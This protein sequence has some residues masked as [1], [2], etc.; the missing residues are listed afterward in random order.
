MKYLVW[1][2][3]MTPKAVTSTNAMSTSCTRLALP[4]MV[5]AEMSTDIALMVAS[6]ILGGEREMTEKAPLIHSFTYSLIWQAGTVQEAEDTIAEQEDKIPPPWGPLMPLLGS[7]WAPLMG[8]SIPEKLIHTYSSL[9]RTLWFPVEE[10]LVRK[11][12]W[13]TEADCSLGDPF[14]GLK[15]GVLLPLLI[16]CLHLAKMLNRGRSFPV[17][18]PAIQACAPLPGSGAWV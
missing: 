10:F 13:V 7:P 15:T 6:L 4:R 1:I 2:I 12:E 11:S 9:L 8:T 18:L 5:P 14:W 17:G 3:L 16:F